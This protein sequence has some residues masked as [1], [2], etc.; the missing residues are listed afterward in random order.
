MSALTGFNNVLIRFLEKVMKWYPE[1]GDLRLIYRGVETLKKYNPRMVLD[2][3]LFYV[4]PYYMEIFNKKEEFFTDLKNLMK[5]PN[6]QD[7]MKDPTTHSN[8][9]S[10][11]EQSDASPENVSIFQRIVVFKEVYEK[12]DNDRKAYVWKMFGALL[13]VGA[14][15][16]TNES[17]K[18]ILDYVQEHPELFTNNGEAPVNF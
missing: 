3:F 1:L 18:V 2:Q 12:M 11:M 17:Y 4:G 15:A 10:Q 14:L 9:T 5:D 13:K 8:E 7:A 16:S 6:I